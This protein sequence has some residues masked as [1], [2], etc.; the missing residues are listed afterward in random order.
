MTLSQQK[1]IGFLPAALS[2]LLLA[3]IAMQLANITLNTFF[4]T[5]PISHPVAANTNKQG[6]NNRNSKNP[7]TQ[8]ATQISQK[9][10]LGIAGETKVAPTQAIE[11]PETKLDLT[12][13]GILA[14][15]NEAGLAIISQGKREEKIYKI[16][17]S[18]PGNATLK[19][20][21]A[22]RVLIESSRGLETLR[23][24]LDKNRL[25][26]IANTGQRRSPSNLPISRNNN[27]GTN[28]SLSE[29]RKE[30]IRNP[31]SFTQK[32]SI[33]PAKG[34]DGNLVGYKLKPSKDKKLFNQLG[35]ESGDI[36][37]KL[38]GLDLSDKKNQRR[39]MNILRRSK[40][41]SMIVLRNGQEIQ[42]EQQL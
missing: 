9:H 33:K 27:S 38:N 35:L 13:S 29:L 20:V 12:L 18:L 10:L 7:I 15:G 39:A 19:A 25:N 3:F 28:G 31:L 36:A 22:D 26:D 21:Y 5:V 42:I 8:Y 4:D 1:I 16:G 41:L 14:T 37:V 30:I 40:K 6:A 17:D 2:V 23:I 24:E 32:I 34:D 11:A